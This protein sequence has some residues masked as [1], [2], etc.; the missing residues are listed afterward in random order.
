MG[1]F[2]RRDCVASER[3]KGNP[4]PEEKHVGKLK[5]SCSRKIKKKSDIV[6]YHKTAHAVLLLNGN[7]TVMFWL[8]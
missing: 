7:L 5:L 2:I 6:A 1:D 8:D 4:I 3:N